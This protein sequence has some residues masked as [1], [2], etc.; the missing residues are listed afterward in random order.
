GAWSAFR[1]AG[2]VASLEPRNIF[3]A[4]RNAATLIR[5]ES[6]ARRG[7][8]THGT[9]RTWSSPY[10]AWNTYA[11]SAPSSEKTTGPGPCAPEATIFARPDATSTIINRASFWPAWHE[12]IE[13]ACK[14]SV[15]Q[16]ATKRPASEMAASPKP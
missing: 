12:K 8:P 16:K 11:M 7:A 2:Y 15:S 14:H 6:P 3:V 4:L 9:A 13:S 10:S 5:G 1:V